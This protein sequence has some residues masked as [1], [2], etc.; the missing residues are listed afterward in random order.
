M[1]EAEEH[2]LSIFASGPLCSV[3]LTVFYS[4]LLLARVCCLSITLRH[5]D[6]QN[7]YEAK[8]SETDRSP[9]IEFLC[10]QTL[11]IDLTSDL[12]GKLFAHR[13]YNNKNN[14]NNNQS[15]FVIRMDMELGY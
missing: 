5:R 13:P 6:G 1:D 11:D 14:N 4:Q 9:R 15:V 2:L 8:E 12:W 10:H 7:K 3:D